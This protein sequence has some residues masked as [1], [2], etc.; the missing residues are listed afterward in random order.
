MA[1]LRCR[2]TSAPG[3]RQPPPLRLLRPIAAAGADVRDAST[4]QQA[5][6]SLVELSVAGRRRVQLGGGGSGAAEQHAFASIDAPGSGVAEQGPLAAIRAFFLPRG[7][8]HSVTPDY[9][10]YQLATVPAH[11]TGWMSHSLATSS[12]IQALG[13]AASP[14]AAVATSAAIKWITKD[15][16]GAAGRLIVGGNLAQVFDEDPRRWRMVAEAVTT[17]GL[18]LEIATRMYPAQFVLLA[19]AGT[20]AK[21][22]AK[23]MGRPCFRVIQTHFSATNNVGDVAAKEEVWEVAAQLLGLASSV[24]LLR[25]LEAA[26]QPELVVPAWAAAH[27]VHVALRYVALRALRFPYPNQK[28]GSLM[29]TQHVG[30]GSVP[31]IEEANQSEQILLPPSACRPRMRFGCSLDEALGWSGSGGLLSS[32]LGGASSSSSSSSSSVGSSSGGSSSSSSTDGGSQAQELQQL[33]AL[34]AGERYMLTWRDGTAHVL[35]QETA[36]PVDLLRAMWQAAWLERYAG[37]GKAEAAAAAGTGVSTAAAGGGNGA[38]AQVQLSGAADAQLL[39][40][41]LAALQQQWPDF[42]AAAAAQGWHLEKAVLP[43]GRTLVRLE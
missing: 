34:Y 33:V 3:A 11:I 7:W 5:P 19:G 18:S 21:S 6:R 43:R 39:E 1:A 31:S 14:E 10:R 23:G 8:P 37:T 20:L 28:R 26:G 32:P 36:A 41:S 15:G 16:L 2:G 22:M 17:L 42:A 40:A 25:T 38:T 4:P 12:M 35:L 30:S 29:V 13:V 9:L 24:A 27:G